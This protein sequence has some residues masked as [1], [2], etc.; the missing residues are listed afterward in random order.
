MDTEQVKE[1]LARFDALVAEGCE[2][3]TYRFSVAV[4]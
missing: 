1:W 4:V 2:S 3:S